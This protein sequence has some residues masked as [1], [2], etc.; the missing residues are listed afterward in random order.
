MNASSGEDGWEP[1]TSSHVDIV[2][3]VYIVKRNISHVASS[4][5]TIVCIVYIAK[6]N[7]TTCCTMLETSCVTC[8]IHIIYAHTSKLQVLIVEALRPDDPHSCQVDA[9]FQ[10]RLSSGLVVPVKDVRTRCPDTP[11]D[12]FVSHG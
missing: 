1:L 8:H 6:I 10:S 4:H 9:R 5:T 12:G 2:C 7:Y 3:V 11:S